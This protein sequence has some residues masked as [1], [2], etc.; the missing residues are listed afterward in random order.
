MLVYLV[1]LKNIKTGEN[2]SR[3]I[4]IDS[5]TQERAEF[6]LIK[7]FDNLVGFKYLRKDI[8][9]LSLLNYS[10]DYKKPKSIFKQIEEFCIDKNYVN[11]IDLIN[12][13]NINRYSCMHY[14]YK[15][16]FRYNKSK[17]IYEKLY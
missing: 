8:L 7:T 3:E 15:L 13:L 5:P 11:H 9:P 12:L 2:H 6:R 17:K 14:L 10:D 1:T 16:G 4:F